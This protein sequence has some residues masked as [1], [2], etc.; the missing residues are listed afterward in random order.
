MAL[1]NAHVLFQLPLLSM[2]PKL[3]SKFS[4]QVR[5]VGVTLDSRLSFDAY[6]SALSKSC[7]YH[8]GALRHIRPNLTLDCFKNIACRLS[9][10]DSTLVGSRLRTFLGFNVCKAHS[11]VLSHVNGDASESPRLCRCFIGFLS[12]GA[13][14]IKSP[15]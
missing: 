4:N 2:S 13:Y 1:P 8:I 10:A 6:S 12:S 3:L 14:T 15:L 11:L 5:I 9:Y 7:F